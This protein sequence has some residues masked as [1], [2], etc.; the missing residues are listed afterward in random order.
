MKRPIPGD[1]NGKQKPNGDWFD[2][3]GKYFS[4]I[5]AWLLM[6]PFGHKSSLTAFKG[7]ISMPFGL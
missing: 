4:V 6:E 7:A 2:N 1:S 5:K 3:R